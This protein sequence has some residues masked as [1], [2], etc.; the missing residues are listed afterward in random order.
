ML[1]KNKH[2][3]DNFFNSINEVRNNQQS[4][5]EGIYVPNVKMTIMKIVKKEKVKYTKLGISVL[6]GG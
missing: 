5:L 1:S 2:S 3:I 6:K 4:I